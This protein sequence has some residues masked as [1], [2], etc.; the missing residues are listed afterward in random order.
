VPEPREVDYIVWQNRSV[1]FYL[2][3]RL[4][5]LSGLVAPAAFCAQQALE[6]LLKAT[7][8]YWDRSFEP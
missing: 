6:A 7:L 5:Y 8:K 3:A 1:R 4:C 2:G